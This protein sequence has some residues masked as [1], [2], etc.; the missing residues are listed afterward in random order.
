MGFL[1]FL[2]VVAVA[3]VIIV[4]NVK[5][6]KREKVEKEQKEKAEAE[7]REK[8]KAEAELREKERKE[9]E[10]AQWQEDLRTGKIDFSKAETFYNAGTMLVEAEKYN[11]A[12]V[13]FTKAIEFNPRY[14]KAYNNRG[15]AYKKNGQVD[16]AIDDYKKA[17]SFNNDDAETLYNLGLAYNDKKDF[18]NAGFYLKKS[19]SSPNNRLNSSA[20]A[21]AYV[22]L[23]VSQYNLGIAGQSFIGQSGVIPAVRSW[24]NALNYDP[25]NSE[26]KRLIEMARQNYDIESTLRMY[27]R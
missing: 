13:Q 22:S 9:K 27:L 15:I 11:D 6:N 17:L 8:E 24:I 18:D 7:L 25:N 20:T 4:V 14:E 1:V 16:K 26:A 2:M 3:V 10:E 21:N 19:L 5:K 23:G 12:I